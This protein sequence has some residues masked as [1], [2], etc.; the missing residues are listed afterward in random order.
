MYL[1]IC[2]EKKVYTFGMKACKSNQKLDVM[3]FL[4]VLL[5]IIVIVLGVGLVL[6]LVI[7][8]KYEFERSTTIDAC[9]TEVEHYAYG[10]DHWPEWGPWNT[11]QTTGEAYEAEYEF[12]GEAGT[13]GSG[14]SWK[15]DSL[16]A[17]SITITSLEDD[18]MNY[19][20]DFTEPYEDH[21]DGFMSV[22]PADGGYQVTW[23][24]KGELGAIPKILMMFG[25]TMDEMVGESFDTGLATLKEIVEALPKPDMVPEEKTM[26]AVHFIGKMYE[27]NTSDINSD[28]Y[29]EGYGA[30]MGEMMAQG[31][32][33]D[34]NSRPFARWHEFDMETMD[35]KME[36]GLPIV[37]PVEAGEGFTSGTME[38]CQALVGSHFGSYET[39][40]DMW[41]KMEAYVGCTGA[42]I[43]YPYEL[44]ITDPESQ[45]DTA[46]WQTDIVYPLL[47]PPPKGEEHDTDG[48]SHEDGDTADHDHDGDHDHDDGD[49]DHNHEDGDA[50]H[51]HHDDAEAGAEGDA[52][53]E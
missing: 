12:F 24:M 18:R 11:S 9:A 36:L 6:S 31:A 32:E 14:Y 38:E 20:L 44:Y 37:A 1:P 34:V 46:Q 45:P 40:G 21:S 13:V 47:P 3:K 27:L 26:P 5:I 51:H 4:K 28:L 35:G 7:D 22:T 33:F 53:A 19:S 15:G 2:V 30:I 23:G 25:P 52:D 8:G 42:S 43:G 41:T 50:D 49:A 10:F 17:G 29:A 48:H 16:G 39:A